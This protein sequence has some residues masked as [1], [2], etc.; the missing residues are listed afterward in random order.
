MSKP[1]KALRA[2]ITLN[3]KTKRMESVRDLNNLIYAPTGIPAK[4]STKNPDA[5]V[6]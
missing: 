3:L 2:F 6:F 1:L 4:K 5:S